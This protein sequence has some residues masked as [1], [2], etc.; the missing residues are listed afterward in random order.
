MPVS[1]QTTRGCTKIFMEY[2]PSLFF[3]S[4][5]G[6][7]DRPNLRLHVVKFFTSRDSMAMDTFIVLELNGGPLLF[8]TK[9]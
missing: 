5:V 9:L 2:R 4:I 3:T 8:Y 1:L 6:R 7:I